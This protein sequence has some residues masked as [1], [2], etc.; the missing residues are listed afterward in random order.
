MKTIRNTENM[1]RAIVI[2]MLR[3]QKG[4]TQAELAEQVD[5]SPNAE[6]SWEKG[7]AKP[8]VKHWYRLCQIFGIPCEANVQFAAGEFDAEK[9]Q[10]MYLKREKLCPICEEKVERAIHRYY[11][12][13]GPQHRSQ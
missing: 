7:S 2:R 6:Y 10:V 9:F 12:D 4:L 8:S 1:K 11:E 13:A 5:V 3:E